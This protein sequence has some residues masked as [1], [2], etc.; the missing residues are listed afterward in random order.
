MA[1]ERLLAF[2]FKIISETVRRRIPEPEL[3]YERVRHFFNYNQDK[4]DV[5]KV[6]QLFDKKAK[7]K[8]KL[9]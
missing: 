6:K 7:E 5:K 8:S 1:W 4:K 9:V 3:L 2:N